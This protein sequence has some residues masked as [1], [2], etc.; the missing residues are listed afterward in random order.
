MLHN[1]I[2]LVQELVHDINY[3][4]RGGNVIFKLDMVK[5]YDK[6]S[7][8]FVLQM[9]QCFGFSDCWVSLIRR[10]IYGPWFSILVNRVSHGFF[11]SQGGLSQGD[12]LSP[13][14]FII[15]AEFLTRGLD[16]LYSQYPSLEYVMV[17]SKHV[18][19]LSFVDDIINFINE[20]R[21]S[22]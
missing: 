6:M 15:V 9:L 12:P 22:L 19:H 10:A 20:S 7:W 21:S 17:T 2:L 11:Q 13:C 8:S 4:T 5:A 3:R 14:L 1:N 16:H 18:A